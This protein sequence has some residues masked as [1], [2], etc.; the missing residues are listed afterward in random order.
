MPAAKGGNAGS[1]GS[2]ERGKVRGPGTPKLTDEE[3]LK[4]RIQR[5]AAYDFKQQCRQLFPI[6]IDGLLEGMENGEFVG[7]DRVRVFEALRDTLHGK[8]AQ[9]ISG[10]D[11]GPIAA[12]FA[13]ML[14]SM[15]GAKAEKLVGPTAEVTVADAHPNGNGNGGHNGNGNHEKLA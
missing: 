13:V 10:P 2:K 15:N 7:G 8:P 6:A 11:G 1:F 14:A 9:V 3:K 4:R 12:T 5:A